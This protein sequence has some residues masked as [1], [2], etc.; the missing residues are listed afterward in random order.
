[1]ANM[2]QR[3]PRGVGADTGAVEITVPAYVSE[4]QPGPVVTKSICLYESDSGRRAG[5]L[6]LSVMVGLVSC[7]FLLENPMGRQSLP[8]PSSNGGISIAGEDPAWGVFGGQGEQAVG[9]LVIEYQVGAVRRTVYADLMSGT[10]QLPPCDSVM[11]SAA[12]RNA[13]GMTNDWTV[14]VQAAVTPG[15]MTQA[16]SLI[17]S[18]VASLGP[19][20][21]LVERDF[22]VPEGATKARTTLNVYQDVLGLFTG[23]AP[24]ITIASGTSKATWQ[25]LA[26][27]WVD[28][29]AFQT[30]CQVQIESAAI[31]M[32]CVGGIQW[33]IDL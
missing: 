14:F 28:F 9:S 21:F 10:Y 2:F 29:P 22:Q 15:S 18:D 33:R 24:T 12:L 13:G 4:G 20:P 27:E 25:A 3:P 30:H 8:F 16:Q 6:L 32:F 23:V 17:Y 5:P 1:M 31:S 19:D 26:R 7:P 11:V